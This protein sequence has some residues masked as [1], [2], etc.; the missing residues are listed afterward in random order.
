MVKKPKLSH[1]RSFRCLCFSTILNNPD[2]FS[3]RSEKCVLIGFST[4]KKAYKVYNLESKMIFHSRDVQF[5]ETIFPFKMNSKLKTDQISD[6]TINDLNFFDEPFN[7]KPNDERRGTN[8]P[9]DDGGAGSC[10]RS[11]YTS[12]D[13]GINGTATSMG[14]NTLSEGNV[15][16]SSNSDIAQTFPT[17]NTSQE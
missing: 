10:P 3:S 17:Q 9:Y 12:D 1:L 8:T 13:G 15:P 16:S 5:Y 14:D 2:K 6:T 4:T 11:T 7:Q